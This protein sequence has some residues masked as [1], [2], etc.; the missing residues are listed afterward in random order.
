MFKK[1][2]L[3]RRRLF[4]PTRKELAKEIEDLRQWVGTLHDEHE[5]TRDQFS[6]DLDEL[7]NIAHQTEADFDD[8][9]HPEHKLSLY[10]SVLSR[11]GFG[12]LM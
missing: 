12:G 9:L 8:R 5:K 6:D 11:A 3:L 2:A 10:P 7:S 4:G 1:I